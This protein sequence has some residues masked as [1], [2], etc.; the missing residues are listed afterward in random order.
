MITQEKVFQNCTPCENF[1]L[2]SIEE[3]HSYEDPQINYCFSYGFK[4]G[5]CT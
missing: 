3:N 5:E 2:I 4:G 1:E